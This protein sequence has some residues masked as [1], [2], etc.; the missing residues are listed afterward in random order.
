MVFCDFYPATSTDKKGDFEDLREAIDKLSPQRRR[1]HLPGRHSEALGF[2]FR[3]GFLGLLHMD[4]VQER[5]E[6]EATSRSSRPRPPS[7]TRPKRPTARTTNRKIEVHNPA[8]LPDM[9]TIKEIREPIVKLEII[10]PKKHRR[11]HEALPGTPRHLQVK[12]MYVSDT[13]QILDLRD[14]LAEI[15]YDFY[16]KLK[17]MTA[18]TAPWTTRSSATAAETARQGRCPHQRQPGRGPLPHR[19]PRK[20][21]AARPPAPHQAQASRSTAT[22]SRSPCRRHRRQD[23]RPRNHQGPSARTSP[24]SA[25]AATSRANASSRE[26]EEGQGAHEDRGIGRHPPGGV[27]GGAGRVPS[28]SKPSLS[29]VQ[30]A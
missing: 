30:R 26:A 28:M 15:I 14:P 11:P 7:P 24:P 6:R 3:C 29:S 22:S 12:Q 2:G 18:A 13:R 20:G 4:I 10:C 21:R 16:D 8:D 17:G 25:T 27:H 23:H 9:G 1:V 19:P 5:L